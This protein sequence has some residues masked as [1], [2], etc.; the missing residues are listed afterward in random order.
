MKKPKGSMRKK[1]FTIST[2]VLWVFE[3]QDVLSQSTAA[4]RREHASSLTFCSLDHLS[5]QR[6]GDDGLRKVLQVPAQ[7]VAQD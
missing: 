5:A 6:S 7:A 4:L 2:D 3:A 1:V